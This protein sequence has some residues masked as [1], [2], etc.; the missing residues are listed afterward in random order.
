MN[1]MQKT[2]VFAGAALVAIILAWEPWQN[3][4]GTTISANPGVTRLFPKF[5][6]AKLAKSIQITKF[7][8]N[9]GSLQTFSVKQVNGRW[10]IP[11][12]QNY[13]A[14]AREHMA[15][16]A[17]AVNDLETLN[18]VSDRPGDFET[19][20]VIAPDA[21]KLKPG[22][23]GVGLE[24][25]FR[26][27]VDKDEDALLADL[28]IGKKDKDQPDV[29][30]VRVAGHDQIYKVKL[31]TDKL[32]TKFQDWIEKDL[33]K[34][35]PLD[36]REL[37]L[38]DY[39]IVEGVDPNGRRVRGIEPHSNMKLSYDEEKSKWSIDEFKEFKAG[40]TDAVEAKLTADEELNTDKLNGLKS[41]LGDL[42]IIDVQ[43]K[44]AGLAQDL[45]AGD[46]LTRNRDALVNLAERGFF[47]PQGGQTDLY[48]SEG[49][50]VT[51]L[52][53]GIEYTLRFGATAVA[54]AEDTDEDN[55]AEDGKAKKSRLSRYL[56]VTSR[57][58]EDRIPKPELQEVPPG[59][60][61][62]KKP[63]EGQP[64]E[65]QPTDEKADEKKTDAPAPAD[66]AAPATGKQ[67]SDERP[68]VFR[69]TADQKPAAKAPAPATTPPAA[70]AT[71]PASAAPPAKAAPP[72]TATPPAAAPA[73]TTPAEPMPPAA[74]AAPD[75]KEATGKF[76]AQAREAKEL[77][78][79]RAIIEKDNQRKQA[80]YDEKIKKGRERNKQLNERFADWYY[81]ISDEVYHKIHLTRA[82]VIKS[83]DKKPGEG[84]GPLDLKALEKA[85]LGGLKH[86]H[87]HD[88][89]DHEKK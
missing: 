86:D 44:P 4:G 2:G 40:G 82:D 52:K 26:G 31:S 89:H 57:F 28:I 5:R 69:L 13:P 83:K 39:S 15:A 46:E 21:S 63:A 43:R 8:E 12:H 23:T 32:S 88:D 60:D 73:A 62:D 64:A 20:G 55:K 41:A 50:V 35:N 74:D 48:S 33:L 18:M 54:E 11:S 17:V 76:R 61:D 78:D 45:K 37:Q 56:M 42:K 27:N 14:D 34:L 85:G 49:E 65:G 38:N 79:K 7:N 6:E 75:E 81:V 71:P 53:D 9:N 29:R 30:F 47:V 77:A 58:L 84:D 66:K 72:A 3:L 70:A 67:S 59:P 1:E 22:A 19:F 68:N 36:I 25:V 87:D 51:Y 16:A 24:V 80:A 10:V